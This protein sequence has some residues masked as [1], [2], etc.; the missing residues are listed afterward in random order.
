[1]SE[2]ERITIGLGVVDL[3]QIDRLI[4]KGLFATRSEFI[5]AAVRSHLGQY[6]DDVVQTGFKK[7]FVIG[8]MRLDAHDL[9][10]SLSEGK[11]LDLHIV[12][13]LTLGKDISPELARKAIRSISIYG[14]FHASDTVKA[15]LQDR[16]K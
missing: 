4:D 7:S 12:G 8:V 5:R 10:D 16:T 3:G 9:E 6:R 13:G 14:S 1:M 11:V 2:S 15:A